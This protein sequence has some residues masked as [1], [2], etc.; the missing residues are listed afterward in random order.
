MNAENDELKAKADEAKTESKRKLLECI[1]EL[2]VK[3]EIT[4]GELKQ[5]KK[6]EGAPGTIGKRVSK[7]AGRNSRMDFQRLV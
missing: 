4:H 1:D 7:K 5:L 3:K 2:R 6:P